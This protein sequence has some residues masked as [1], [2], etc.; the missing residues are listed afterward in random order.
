LIALA[1]I[2]NARSHRE[3]RINPLVTAVTIALIARW[4]GYFAANQVQVSASLWPVVYAI[5]LGFSAISI[6]FIATNRAMELPVALADRLISG[7]RQIGDRMMFMRP[8]RR[9]AA[10]GGPA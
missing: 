7:L 6:W 3:S 2:G 5:P 9:G 8:W 1:V 4:A 10:S